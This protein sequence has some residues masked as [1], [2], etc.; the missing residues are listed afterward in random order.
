MDCMTLKLNDQPLDFNQVKIEDS[1]NQIFPDQ[2][3]M[4]YNKQIRGTIFQKIGFGSGCQ[5]I[6]RLLKYRCGLASQIIKS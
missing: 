4:K 3:D 6:G 2:R 5:N 1:I